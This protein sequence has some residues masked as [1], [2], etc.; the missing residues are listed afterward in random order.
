MSYL[1]VSRCNFPLSIKLYAFAFGILKTISYFLPRNDETTHHSVS[2]A[3]QVKYRFDFE[4]SL[5]FKALNGLV[6]QYTTDLLIAF[7]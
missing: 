7:S 4:I 6:L 2:P 1:F 3:L 5:V